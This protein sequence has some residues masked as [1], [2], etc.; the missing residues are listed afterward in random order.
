MLA[1]LVII[2]IIGVVVVGYE[3]LGAI[4]HPFEIWIIRKR[5]LNHLDDTGDVG[6]GQRDDFDRHV[7]NRVR[8]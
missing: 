3:Y 5:L 2:I 6:F 8:L 4:K 1:Y 7:D